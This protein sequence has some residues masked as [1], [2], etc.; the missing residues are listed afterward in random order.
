MARFKVEISLFQ[1]N[2]KLRKVTKQCQDSPSESTSW[3]GQCV[4]L[5]E[6]NIDISHMYMTDV[7]PVVGAKHKSVE[8]CYWIFSSFL[9]LGIFS[10]TDVKTR[11]A[12]NHFYI[13]KGLSCLK[14]GSPS[15]LGGHV[16]SLLPPQS[17]AAPRS[18]NI[19]VTWALC[20]VPWAFSLCRMLP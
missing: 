10:T 16:S 13:Q 18:T 5:E 2:F 6:R 8:K 20:S 14:A 17:V 9:S 4:D 1:P 15:C 12:M 7:G 3:A 19:L 11:T